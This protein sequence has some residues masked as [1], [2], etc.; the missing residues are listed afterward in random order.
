MIRESMKLV[1]SDQSCAK[2]CEKTTLTTEY[3]CG[4]SYRWSVYANRIHLFMPASNEL[5]NPRPTQNL[6]RAHLQHHG[7]LGAFTLMRSLSA[8]AIHSPGLFSFFF[9][10]R[11]IDRRA[12]C[13]DVIPINIWSHVEGTNNM[14]NQIA[15]TLNNPAHS[16]P[17]QSLLPMCTLTKVIAI[18]DLAILLDFLRSPSEVDSLRFRFLPRVHLPL[19]A[20][21]FVS[22]SLPSPV[23]G[24]ASSVKL[25]VVYIS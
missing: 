20:Y 12:S 25:L 21:F 19:R 16:L 14:N 7:P 5:A 24:C 6:L 22:P 18:R 10:V 2:T 23:C 15:F 3:A 8:R 4:T 9:F 17:Q 11:H 1:Q 13:S